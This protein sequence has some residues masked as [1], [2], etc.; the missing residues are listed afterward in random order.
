MLGNLFH[1]KGR[2]TYLQT[3]VIFEG[4]FIDGKR[5][6][7]G[8][9]HYPSK[10]PSDQ[11]YTHETTQE[12]P[13][14]DVVYTQLD[15]TFENDRIKGIPTIKYPDGDVYTG[16][17]QNGQMEGY[18]RYYYK[19]SNDIYIGTFVKGL[20]E[21]TGLIKF[22]IRG[23]PHS[24]SGK[25]PNT[26]IDLNTPFNPHAA[27]ST[28][29]PIIPT[30]SNTQNNTSNNSSSSS[31]NITALTAQ[32]LTDCA[33]IYIGEFSHDKFSGKGKY[34]GHNGIYF[35]EF[36]RGMKEGFGSLLYPNGNKYVGQFLRGIKQGQGVLSYARGGE[37][38]GSWDG[39]MASGE[40]KCKYANGEVY[41]GHFAQGRKH[42]PGVLTLTSGDILKA[43]WDNDL[44]NG[45]GSIYYSNGVI[46]EGGIH[47]DSREG[48]GTLFDPATNTKFE[49]NFE[50]N[51]RH[52]HGKIV[53][54]DM[55][56]AEATWQYGHVIGEMIYHLAPNSIWNNPDF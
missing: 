36:S 38:S 40:G 26:D 14:N 24:I 35:G 31:N 8:V 52:G 46:Y 13:Q 55:S 2:L 19:D 49:G 16:P 1:G 29:S 48:Y 33:E 43:T 45:K 11:H 50:Q 44:P 5:S 34:I 21:G 15:A 39:D 7:P 6:G 42:G 41:A 54:T 51:K 32:F 23:P 27:S 25:V 30:T 18:G 4:S 28:A 53:F 10:N 9:V 47:G 17:I 20:R 56:Y 3:G 12:L 37:Y 22:N